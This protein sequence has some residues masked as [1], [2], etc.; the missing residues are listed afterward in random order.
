LIAQVFSAGI[1][2]THYARASKSSKIHR[3]RDVKLDV[4]LGSEYFWVALERVPIIGGAVIAPAP[5]DIKLVVVVTLPGKVNEIL[6]T[7][8]RG[9]HPFETIKAIGTCMNPLDA[10]L[11]QKSALSVANLASDTGDDKV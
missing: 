4:A 8:D 2:E 11:V 3:C 7:I 9:A 1:V 5:T 10:L 6:D